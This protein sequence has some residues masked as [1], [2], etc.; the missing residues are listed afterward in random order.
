MNWMLKR[1]DESNLP[2][3]FRPYSASEVARLRKAPLGTHAAEE[4]KRLLAKIAKNSEQ[5]R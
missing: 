4:R 1:F 5:Q 2:P 3:T